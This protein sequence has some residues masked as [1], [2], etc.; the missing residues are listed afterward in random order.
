MKKEKNNMY[1]LEKYGQKTPADQPDNKLNNEE[2]AAAINRAHESAGTRSDL[3]NAWLDH[4]KALLQIQRDRA[5][6]V[7]LNNIAE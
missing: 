4:L 5:K 7:S 3:Q 6:F 1:T 2:L